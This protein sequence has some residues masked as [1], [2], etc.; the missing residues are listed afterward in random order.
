MET[1]T[2]FP[3]P[4]LTEMLEPEISRL[5][6]SEKKECISIARQ[7]GLQAGRR[8][9]QLFFAQR[10]RDN[11]E[12]EMLSWMVCNN[13]RNDV[14]VLWYAHRDALDDLG[15]IFSHLK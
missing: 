14:N 9:A 8:K 4:T 15:K 2:L 11:I 5:S 13:W 7:Q 10:L 6:S 1:N 3:L 12:R